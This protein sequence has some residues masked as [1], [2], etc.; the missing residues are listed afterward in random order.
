MLNVQVWGQ[1]ATNASITV[2]D[3]TGKTIRIV[4]VVNNNARIDMSGMAQG[5]YLIRYT[6]AIRTETIKV[7]KQ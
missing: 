5:V 7:N 6:D 3:I 2:S 4:S 1:T